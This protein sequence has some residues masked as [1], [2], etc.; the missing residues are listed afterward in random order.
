MSHTH[1]S[2]NVQFIN[3]SFLRKLEEGHEKTAGAAASAFVRQK[4][5]EESFTRKIL[6]PVE[7]TAADLD[8][9]LDDTPRI[10]CEKEPDSVAARL[11]LTGTPEVR[12]FRGPRYP[13]VFEKL[14]SQTFKKSKYE[15]MTY[16]TDIRQVLQDNS[17][18]DLHRQEDA[19]FWGN[20]KA[21]VAAEATQQEHTYDTAAGGFNGANL[22]TLIS[23]LTDFEQKPGHVVL[24]WSKYLKLLGL[25]AT[26]I[27]DQAATEHFRGGPLDGFYGF[28]L[29]P[30]LKT[31][32]LDGATWGAGAGVGI[33]APQQYL[34]QFYALEDATVAL[35]VEQDVIEFTTYEAIGIGLGNIHGFVLGEFES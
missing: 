1:D 9:D 18:K 4:L 20:L 17:V 2:I 33:F 10:I 8:R 5:R 25:P 30:T 6:P 3:Q 27:G 21:I 32:I 29:I 13:V 26:S 24:A 19:G 12:V 23:K 16:R 34:G 7:V 31:D 22:M 15:L 28:N 35:K 11:S 14:S